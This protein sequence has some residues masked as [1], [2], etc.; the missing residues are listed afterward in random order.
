MNVSVMFI[1]QIKVDKANGQRTRANN[2][3]AILIKYK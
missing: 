3:S 1:V 2:L